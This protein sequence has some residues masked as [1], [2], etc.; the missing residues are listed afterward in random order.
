MQIRHSY[1]RPSLWVRT[2]RVHLC[3]D[4]FSVVNTAGL[5]DVQLI[6][7]EY[8]K[9]HTWKA[10]CEVTG[11]LWMVVPLTPMWSGSVVFVYWPC[12]FPTL[13]TVFHSVFGPTLCVLG[14]FS[15][16]DSLMS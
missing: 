12:I 2:V 15:P 13:E 1:S 9:L 16:Q 14:A 5:Y 6:A 11:G 4:F 7:S 10:D 8:V 3:A